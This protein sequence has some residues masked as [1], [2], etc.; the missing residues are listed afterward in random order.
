MKNEKL[1]NV[2]L[3]KEETLGG[4]N[5]YLKLTYTYDDYNGNKHMVVVPKVSLS[6]LPNYVPRIECMPIYE[7]DDSLFRRNRIPGLYL[8]AEKE[9]FLYLKDDK[10]YL[11]KG[12]VDCKIDDKNHTCKD[13]VAV[14]FIT[15]KAPAP[16]KMTKKEIEKRLGHN[17][18]IVDERDEE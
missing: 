7:Y 5:Y 17:I 4:Y 8:T 9:Y 1:E 16:I 15:K 12:N 3:F 18:E 11:K 2:K 6:F 13:V 10:L 14:D